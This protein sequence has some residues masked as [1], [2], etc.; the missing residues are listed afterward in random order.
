MVRMKRISESDPSPSSYTVPVYQMAG[1]VAVFTIGYTLL[2]P[3]FLA[4]IA[5]DSLQSSSD[6]PL[7]SVQYRATSGSEEQTTE[8]GLRVIGTTQSFVFFYDRK[9]SRNL[10]IPTAQIV[11]M[12]QSLK[13]AS[14]RSQGSDG[15]EKTVKDAS[16]GP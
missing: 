13:S 3:Y 11:E 10:I 5:A 1:I 7:T 12:Q 2:P 14:Q 9:E 4:G 6:E 8:K 15:P 16:P